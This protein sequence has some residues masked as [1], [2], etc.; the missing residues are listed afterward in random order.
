MGRVQALKVAKTVSLDLDLVN[1][2]LEES[3]SMSR[4]F[5]GTVTTLIRIG[6]SV[7]QD[8]RAREQESIR[9]ASRNL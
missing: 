4:D 3:Q 1:E 2:I 5:S 6:L 9:N 7:R 8:Q